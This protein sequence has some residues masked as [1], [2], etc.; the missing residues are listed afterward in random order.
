MYT[1]EE[2]IDPLAEPV[3][4]PLG[5]ELLRKLRHVSQAGGY[6]VVVEMSCQPGTLGTV[7]VGVAEDAYRVQPGGGEELAERLDVGF[8]LPRKAD[9]EVAPCSRL[10]ALRT[11]LIQK[12]HEALPVAE[13]AHPPQH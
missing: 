13:P 9:D 10:W 11:D 7:L 4:G 3:L 1:L 8:G 2:Y 5:R 6:L 12:R